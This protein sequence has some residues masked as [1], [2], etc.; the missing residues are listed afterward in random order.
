MRFINQLV[1]VLVAATTLR[2]AAAADLAAAATK[3]PARSPLSPLATVA[4][5]ADY[6]RAS[7]FDIPRAKSPTY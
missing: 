5:V 3:P 6:V 4:Y 7:S 2:T 1:A